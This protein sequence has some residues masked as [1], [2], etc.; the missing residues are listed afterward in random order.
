MSEVL[1]RIEAAIGSGEILTVTYS[2][3][4]KPGSLR[5]LLPVGFVG[6]DKVRARCLSSGITKSFIIEKLSIVNSNTGEMIIGD[7]DN[8]IDNVD[9]LDSLYEKIKSTIDKQKYFVDIKPEILSIHKIQKNGKILKSHVL[10]ISYCEF[11]VTTIFD[12][13][14]SDFIDHKKTLMKPWSVDKKGQHSVSF[15]SFRN[16]ANRFFEELIEFQE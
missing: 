12:C 6:K 8:E 4:N 3:G 13:D 15:K 16:A 11:S 7:L 14:I 1:Q 2:G 10:S 5:E 9:S